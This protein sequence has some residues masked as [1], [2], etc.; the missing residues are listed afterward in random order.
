MYIRGLNLLGHF[1]TDALFTFRM[2]NNATMAQINKT[3]AARFALKH[4]L[5]TYHDGS[6]HYSHT[7]VYN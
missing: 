7:W 2:K 3:R 4:E 1:L 5:P 6:V